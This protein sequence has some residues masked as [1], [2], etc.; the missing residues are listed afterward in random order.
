VDFDLFNLSL[1]ALII[2]VAYMVRGIA[3]FG[4]ALI[5]V[6]LLALLYPIPVVVPLVVFL[7]FVGSASQGMKNRTLIVWR[8]QLPLIPF[9][10]IGIAGGLTLLSS[11]GSASLAQALGAFV[12]LYAIYQLLPLPDLRGP[13]IL[14]IP[15][16]LLGGLVGT[17]FGTGGPFYMIYLTLRGLEKGAARATF[18]ANFLIDGAIRLAAYA[19]VGFFHSEVLLATLAALPVAA[20]G[21]WVGGRVHTEISPR[22]YARMISALLLFSGVALIPKG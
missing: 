8:E 13:R 7:D 4:S 6:P 10:V 9:A 5:S 12:I 3:G 22:G 19:T 1:G 15:F 21:L 18:A 17:L 11:M 16:G 2:F 14:V 20:A